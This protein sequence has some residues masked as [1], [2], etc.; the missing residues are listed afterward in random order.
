VITVFVLRTDISPELAR[1]LIDLDGAGHLVQLLPLGV[2]VLFA[3]A[4]A[5]VTKALGRVPGWAGIVIGA[6]SIVV[7]AGRSLGGGSIMLL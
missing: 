1:A 7:D 5:L 2:F 3:S 6:S 4:A